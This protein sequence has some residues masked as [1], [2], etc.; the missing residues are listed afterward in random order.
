MQ[1]ATKIREEFNSF[2]CDSFQIQCHKKKKKKKKIH[3]PFCFFVVVFFALNFYPLKLLSHFLSFQRISELIKI[4]NF[5]FFHI[6]PLLTNGKT[7]YFNP[8]DLD[9]YP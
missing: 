1:F 7:A 4:N 5:H 2:S 3:F 8:T 6:D 9:L